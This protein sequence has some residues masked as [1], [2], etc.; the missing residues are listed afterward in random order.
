MLVTSRRTGRWVVPKGN[1]P[2]RMSPQEAAARE[3]EEEAGVRG[4][5]DP[6]PV[7]AFRYLKLRESGASEW[8]DVEVYPLALTSELATWKEQSQ[9]T[10]RWFTL[11]D[12][13]SVV[14]EPELAELIRAFRP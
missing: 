8:A 13:A 5:I 11:L 6:T 4:A 3:A 9:R 7:G 10:R 14:E 2:A 1:I 12:A